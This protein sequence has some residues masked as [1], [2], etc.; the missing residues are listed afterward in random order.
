MVLTHV[1][2]TVGCYALA[3]LPLPPMARKLGISLLPLILVN[4]LGVRAGASTG[5]RKISR[6]F[7]CFHALRAASFL[8]QGAGL[9]F[10]GSSDPSKAVGDGGGTFALD[11]LV[12]T[13]A[14][15][16]SAVA[17]GL[18]PVGV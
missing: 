10:R 5:A 16:A 2:L 18:L 14:G 13:L 15:C 17:A 1:F 11:L 12:T 8:T 9:G 7:R 6:C 4:A 3:R